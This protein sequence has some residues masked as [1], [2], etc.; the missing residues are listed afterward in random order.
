MTEQVEAQAKEV[1]ETV[2]PTAQSAFVALQTIMGARPHFKYEKHDLAHD[3]L[4][5]ILGFI[6]HVHSKETAA[7]AP[8]VESE[9]KPVHAEIV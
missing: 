3:A 5:H 1:K 7:Q 6:Q 9:S 4:D 8:V 2:A